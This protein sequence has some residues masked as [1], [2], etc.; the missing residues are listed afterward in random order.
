MTTAYTSLLGLALPVTGE[1]SG[2]WGDTVNTAITS[3]LD[4]AV[5]GTTSITTDAD[6]TLTTTTGAS[7]QARQAI[8][9][10]NPASGTT[11]RNITAPAQSKI[12]TVINAS[13]GT[14][15]IVIRG[16]GPT[17]G[18]TIAK[19][20]S[21]TVAWN[22]SDFV[23]VSSSGGAIT[24]TDLTVTGNTIL[25][26]AAADTLTVNATS[27]FAS[28]VNFQGLV[29][30]PSTGRSAAAALTTTAPAFLY[31]VAST[32]TDTTSSGTIAAMAPFYSIAAPTLS[33]SNVTTYTYAST[34][35]I[36]GAPTAGGSAT[37]TN[38]YALYVNSGATYLAGAVATGSTLAV[39]GATNLNGNV[40]LGD[41]AAD[42][43]TV[44]GTVTSNLIF[45]DNTYDIGASGA[46]RPRNLYLSN[47]GV[48]GSTLAVGKS[49]ASQVLDV[50]SA[51]TTAYAFS[52]S[53]L[54]Q[55]AGGS[56]I[57]IANTGTGGYSSLRFTAL[58]SS[59]A[60]GYLGF[61]NSGGSVTGSFVLGQR[62][63]TT[64]YAEQLR[65]LPNTIIQMADG[66]AGSYRA[67]TK[68]SNSPGLA[69]RGS[70]FGALGGPLCGD[71]SVNAYPT[72][73]VDPAAVVWKGMVT[74][75]YAYLN[76]I[77]GNYGYQWFV[78]NAPV[79]SGSAVT[80]TNAMVLDNNRQLGVGVYPKT[81]Y[82]NRRAIE[83][84]G[85]AVATLALT[86]TISEIMT[87]L[88]YNAAGSAI[89][90]G[91]GY[92]SSYEFNNS[93]SGGW[94]WKQGYNSTGGTTS[95]V[96]TLM[97]LDAGGNLNLGVGNTTASSRLN[98]YTST[99]PVGGPANVGTGAT[100][101]SGTGT[102]TTT[103]SNFRGIGTLINSNH[104]NNITL[105]YGASYDTFGL[106]S[107]AQFTS[108][109]GYQTYG[110]AAYAKT[111]GS[112]YGI[113]T[114]AVTTSTGSAAIGLYIGSSSGSSN[115]NYGIFQYDANNGNY[116]AGPISVGTS[117]VTNTTQSVFLKVGTGSG[118]VQNWIWAAGNASTLPTGATYGVLL[119]TNL[120]QGNSEANIVYGTG[121]GSGQA[122]TFASWTGAAYSEK[123]RF[124]YYGNFLVGIDARTNGVSNSFGTNF[125][126]HAYGGYANMLGSTW[127][128]LVSLTY[129]SFTCA[130]I[131]VQ[132]AENGNVNTTFAKWTVTYAVGGGWVIAGPF[133]EVTSGNGYG[134]CNMR[135]NGTSLE[136]QARNGVSTGQIRYHIRYFSA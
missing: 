85:A 121:V 88:Y 23:K 75:S 14:Q 51:D 41:A 135:V 87:N 6:I 38:P 82:S 128:T 4:T 123:A 108:G 93:V 48:I 133:E 66:L 136:V 99:N 70:I 94:A 65:I 69:V 74:G 36:A 21:A 29:K 24:F 118:S 47:N 124:D 53:S 30:L 105:P 77:N 68:D 81:W 120:S 115:Q 79:T 18:V 130:D 60:V 37:I 45:T 2:T 106:V 125:E 20:E 71:W 58:D 80:F 102:F 26:D 32:Y 11:T 13:G 114:D 122:L 19:G 12:Y 104:N 42:N 129:S 86:P 3:L 17:T 73:S 15:S 109:G 117:Q 131:I 127:V 92:L 1:L 101:Q 8:I 96:S 95:T 72:G 16:A 34:W 132:G 5:A 40:T 7:N 112:A 10:W 57:S 54:F 110:I 56:N 100:I 119:G 103:G 43:I 97:N 61:V 59:N 63:D 98:V 78:S 35:Y 9:L 31:G 126:C 84:G 44:A 33:T 28:P 39:S 134:Q 113:R 67:I 116:F 91:A 55:P 52:S 50:S 25:G 111:D 83:I 46:T 89:N 27:T 107:A 49:S 76:E 64:A 62:T 22:G 90:Y